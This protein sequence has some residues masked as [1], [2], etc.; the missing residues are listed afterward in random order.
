MHNQLL[1]FYAQFATNH[2]ATV[3]KLVKNAELK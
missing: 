2:S 3:N 1:A